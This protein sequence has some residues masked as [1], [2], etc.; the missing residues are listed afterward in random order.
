M[1]LEGAI[2]C[3][4]TFT[5]ADNAGFYTV[6]IDTPV[7]LAGP[8]LRWFLYERHLGRGGFGMIMREREREACS[9]LRHPYIY[10]VSRLETYCRRDPLS[11]LN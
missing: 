3:R 10:A 1:T 8:G 2:D 4:Y 6:S 5:H 11:R 7:G 9:Q